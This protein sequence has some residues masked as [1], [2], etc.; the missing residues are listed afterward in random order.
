MIAIGL[1]AALIGCTPKEPQPVEEPQEEF[2]FLVDQFAD[3]RIMRYQLNDWETL[4]LQQ[5]AYHL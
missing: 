4:T 1:T 5:K 2:K 3:L